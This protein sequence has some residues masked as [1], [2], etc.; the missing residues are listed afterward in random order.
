LDGNRREEDED[1][2]DGQEEGGHLRP[3]KISMTMVV[4]VMRVM[5][6]MR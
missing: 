6:M 2:G 4:A 3:R 1:G 5:V